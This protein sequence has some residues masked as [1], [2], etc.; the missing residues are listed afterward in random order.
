VRESACVLLVVELFD[1]FARLL[2]DGRVPQMRATA[3]C[4]HVIVCIE[5]E[6]CQRRRGLQ[7]KTRVL[8]VSLRSI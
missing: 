3:H 6:R 8:S 1:R 7:F 4:S 2:V 5:E